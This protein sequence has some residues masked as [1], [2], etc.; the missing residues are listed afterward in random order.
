MKYKNLEIKVND[1]MF[2]VCEWS[3]NVGGSVFYFETIDEAKD[4]SKKLESEARN[5][6]NIEI[7]E[8]VWNHVLEEYELLDLIETIEV[9]GW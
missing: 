1:V 8:A 7:V 5:N 4:Y 9:R 3:G 2:T 6:V